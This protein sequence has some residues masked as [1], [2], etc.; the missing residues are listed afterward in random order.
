M[1]WSRLSSESSPLAAALSGAPTSPGQTLSSRGR[2]SSHSPVIRAAVKA[3]CEAIP[4]ADDSM[5]VMFDFVDPIGAAGRFWRQDRPG[6]DEAGRITLDLQC[7]EKIGRRGT[8]NNELGVVFT[9]NSCRL[10]YPIDACPVGA[11]YVGDGYNCA[12]LWRHPHH[13]RRV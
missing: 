10:T 6:N 12:Q 11:E 5:A 4:V 7:P 13:W 8:G 9:C 3:H 1:P 2:R